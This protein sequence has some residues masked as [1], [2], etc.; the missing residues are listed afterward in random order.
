M[1]PRRGAGYTM[2]PFEIARGVSDRA[3]TIHG[4]DMKGVILAAGTGSRL[5]PLASR[6][7]AHQ[8]HIPYSWVRKDG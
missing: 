7:D 6:L 2:A 1:T 5:V 3:R 4:A 8:N